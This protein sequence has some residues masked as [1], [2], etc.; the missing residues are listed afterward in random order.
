[1]NTV[2]NQLVVYAQQHHLIQK[3][4]VCYSVNLLLDLLDLKE[5]ELLEVVEPT[6]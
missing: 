4:D 3:E 6:T 5:F 1:M 2:I